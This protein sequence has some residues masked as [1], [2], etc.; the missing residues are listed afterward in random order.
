MKDHIVWGMIGCGD[1]TE[2][3]NGPGLY[4]AEHSSLKGVW[5]R[6]HAKAVS[7]TERHGHGI[8]YD[9]V[10]A[11]LSGPEIDIVYIATTPDTHA[12]LAI[13]CAEAGKHTLVE[14]PVAPTLEEGKRMQEAFRKA[15]KKCFVFIMMNERTARFSTL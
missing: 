2:V 6:T 14:K 15:G 11:L 3:K 13:R 7:W 9:T 10:D 12:E 4:M 5:N 8:V 1:V